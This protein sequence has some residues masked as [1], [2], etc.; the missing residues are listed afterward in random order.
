MSN[1]NIHATEC[2]GYCDFPQC[3]I[4]EQK[5][6]N[7]KRK[8]KQH[9]KNQLMQQPLYKM[10]NGNGYLN[11]LT[12]TGLS[13]YRFFKHTFINNKESVHLPSIRLPPPSHPPPLHTHTHNILTQHT[14][15]Y[16]DKH[17]HTHTHALLSM[18]TLSC[19]AYLCP[20]NLRWWPSPHSHVT[21]GRR[22]CRTSCCLMTSPD[23]DRHGSVV[24]NDASVV[25]TW[26]EQEGTASDNDHTN[27]PWTDWLHDYRA[28]DQPPL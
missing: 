18:T 7:K 10:H 4:Q 28:T 3:Q 14:H 23:R 25:V 26:A 12:R 24:G 9:N 5:Q 6:Q 11:C 2:S 16:P 15:T 20:Q 27:E 17:T 19:P 8:Q 21:R 22:S 1:V 13:N